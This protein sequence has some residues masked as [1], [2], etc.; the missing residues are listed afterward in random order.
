MGANFGG[1]LA[2]V[3]WQLFSFLWWGDD[4]T[5][6]DFLCFLS[7]AE[8]RKG[9]RMTGR[10]IKKKTL[11]DRRQPLAIESMREDA[12]KWVYSICYTVLKH[13]SKC[14]GWQLVGMPPLTRKSCSSSNF[15]HR[16]FYIYGFIFQICENF[17]S[18]HQLSFCFQGNGPRR[19]GTASTNLSLR[20]LTSW[21]TWN[22]RDTRYNWDC[23]RWNIKYQS[24]CDTWWFTLYIWSLVCLPQIIV[25]L[26]RIQHAQKLW[27]AASNQT[28][29]TSYHMPCLCVS[30]HASSFTPPLS[31]PL[32][33]P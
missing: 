31:P 32:F 9:K 14:S 11:A 16:Y 29:M 26:N 7:Q 4:D 17:D 24:P 10:E 23:Q 20:S 1:F 12:L 13:E 8:S 27:V 21:S 19:C 30:T 2:K 15:I 28:M 22:T 3:V 33:L 18:Y 5:E 6:N 25:L